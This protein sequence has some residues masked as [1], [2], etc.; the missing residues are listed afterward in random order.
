MVREFLRRTFEQEGERVL[1]MFL[2][3]CLVSV[4]P[5]ART[6]ITKPFQE[7]EGLYREPYSHS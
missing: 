1:A 5:I 3:V 6:I 7:L 4:E 2:Y